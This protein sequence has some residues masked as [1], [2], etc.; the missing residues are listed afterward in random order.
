MSEEVQNIISGHS[1]SFDTGIAR[2]L[3]LNAAIVFQHIVYWLRVNSKKKDAELIEG[4]Y[5]MYETQKEI[6]S[7]FEYIS[8]DE[9]YKAIK[10]LVESGILIK[11][12]L[13]P[14]PFDRTSWYTTSDQ[15]IFLDK[16]KL[17]ESLRSRQSTESDSVSERN[18]NPSIDGMSY[19]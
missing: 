9:V 3:G 8:E 16:P 17:K 6:A 18:Q 1:N 12:C 4:K 10:K 2:A 7:Y 13:N 5:W 14:N 15:S 19:T 11:S